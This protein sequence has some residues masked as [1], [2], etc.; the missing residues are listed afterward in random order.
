MP[1]KKRRT[2]RLD[3]E[4]WAELETLAAKRGTTV[5]KVITRVIDAE[6]TLHRWVEY[7]R[8]VGKATDKIDD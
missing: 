6:L 2:I 4:T 3:D 8:V 1:E 5:S 7:L